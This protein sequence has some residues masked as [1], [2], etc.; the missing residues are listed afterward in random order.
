MTAAPSRGQ[1]RPRRTKPRARP[2]AALRPRRRLA[3]AAPS[4]S[5]PRSHTPREAVAGSA[6]PHPPAPEAA[7]LRDTIKDRICS[8]PL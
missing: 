3:V 6:R 1:P 8:V 4:S 2:F 7:P 5:R